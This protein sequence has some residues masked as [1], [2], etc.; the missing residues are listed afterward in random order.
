LIDG[1]LLHSVGDVL[2]QNDV[3]DHD[4]LD[5]DTF[6]LKIQVK[7]LHHSLSMSVSS[8]S[9]SLSRLN[10]SSHCSYSFHDISVD[11]LILLGYVGHKLLNVIG[12]FDDF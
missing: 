12:V 10:S 7:E 9:V 3:G 4:S 8:Q 5:V 2:T 6:A 1:G 11:Q